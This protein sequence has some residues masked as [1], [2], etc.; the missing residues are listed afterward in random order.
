MTVSSNDFTSGLIRALSGRGHTITRDYRQFQFLRTVLEK[1]YRSL[2]NHAPHRVRWLQEHLGYQKTMKFQRRIQ[3]WLALKKPVP[4]PLMETLGV[5]RRD[6]VR[7]MKV[8]QTLFCRALQFTINPEFFTCR[9]IPAVSVSIPLP[10]NTSR[11]D[12]ILI[13]RNY[14]MAIGKKNPS[15]YALISYRD[16]KDIR[17][18]LDGFSTFIYPPAMSVEPGEIRFFSRVIPLTGPG[19]SG[20]FNG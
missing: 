15:D 16:L 18:T 5:S 14:L 20:D 8:E 3:Q 19:F 6:L 17:V 13:V 1:R 11:S 4:G 7:W 9:L 2:R 12:A 10:A